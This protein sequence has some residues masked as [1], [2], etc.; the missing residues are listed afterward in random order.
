MRP[1]VRIVAFVVRSAPSLS[2][3]GCQWALPFGID[4][5]QPL[6]GLQRA[7]G[8]LHLDLQVAADVQHFDASVLEIARALLAGDGAPQRLRSAPLRFPTSARTEAPRLWYAS[9]CRFLTLSFAKLAS[10]CR[11]IRRSERLSTNSP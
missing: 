6:P 3:V 1:G 2:M 9:S 11:A 4:C 7:A 10:A 8:V 5:L